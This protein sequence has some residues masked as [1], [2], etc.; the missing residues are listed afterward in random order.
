[1]SMSERQLEAMQSI[2]ANYGGKCR[3]PKK[4]ENPFKMCYDPVLDT[5]PELELDAVSYYLTVFSIL[6][7]MIK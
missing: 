1:M 4:A 5:S 7:W 6:R 3:L 2:A